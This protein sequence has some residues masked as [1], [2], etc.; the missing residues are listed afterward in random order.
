MLASTFGTL[1]VIPLLFLAQIAFLVAFG[2]LLDT[3]V[4]RTLLVPGL[5]HDLGRAVWWPWRRNHACGQPSVESGRCWDGR[6]EHVVPEHLAAAL[7]AAGLTAAGPLDTRDGRPRW[8]AL[9]PDG[10]RW[11]VGVVGPERADAARRRAAVLAGVEHPHLA[12]AGPVLEAAD[13]GVLALVAAEPGVDLA[14]LLGA[15]GPLDDAEAV[16]VLAPVAGALAALHAG[17]LAHGD[18]TAADVVLTDGGP[19]LADV[20]GGAA[21][22]GEP[23]RCSSGGRPRTWRT[24]LRSAAADRGRCHGSGGGGLRAGHGPIGVGP[25]GPAA[26]CRHAA[27]GGPARPGGAGPPGAS[28]ARGAARGPAP[29][30]VGRRRPVG[31]AVVGGRGGMPGRGGP[32]AHRAGDACSSDS[33]SRWWP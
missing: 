31:T 3:L 28:E 23:R 33:G 5:V 1:A 25:A 22:V 11:A 18:L 12:V 27:A 4:V 7:R 20:G 21:P 16:G 6:V 15:R 10:R 30:R 9:D 19:V 26:R 8:T 32:G 13:G 17:G 29:G 2:V 14:V 24:W